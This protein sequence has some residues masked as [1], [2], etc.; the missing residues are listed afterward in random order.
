MPLKMFKCD[1]HFLSF[2]QFSQTNLKAAPK[3]NVSILPKTSFYK[4]F[5]QLK[6][7]YFHCIFFFHR[8]VLFLKMV[9]T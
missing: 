4:R 8:L 6:Q 7:I 5:Q 2:Q 9:K 1:N 3:T